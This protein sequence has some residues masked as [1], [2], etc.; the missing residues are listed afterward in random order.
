ML[1]VD[2]HFP[3]GYVC[4][5]C[6]KTF[7]D[8]YANVY[9]CASKQLSG[10]LDWCKEQ[11]WYE[12]TTIVISGD[13]P[14]MDHDFC[15]NVPEEYERTVYTAYVNAPVQPVSD[16][17]RDF[18]TF[19]DFPTTLAALGVEID[20]DRL[21]LGTNLY[22]DVPTLSEQYGRAKEKEEL[23]KKSAL[24]EK[25][26]QIDEQAAIESK[27]AKELKEKQKKEKAAAESRAA[28]ASKAAEKVKAEES[29]AAKE[30]KVMDSS[31]ADAETAASRSE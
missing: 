19:D 27:E 26:G 24:M 17:R 11:D 3:D 4:P 2:T 29:S 16:Q 7:D 10:F 15:E 8:Q 23:E 30:T 12:N 21:G 31:A 5:L 9:N 22:S 20:G 28:E 13:H 1:T 6:P 25:L 14:T 18:T